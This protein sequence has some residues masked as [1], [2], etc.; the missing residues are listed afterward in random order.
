MFSCLYINWYYLWEMR[1]SWALEVEFAKAKPAVPNYYATL[2]Y[3]SHGFAFNIHILT[4]M[5][6]VLIFPYC[7][8]NKKADNCTEKQHANIGVCLTRVLQE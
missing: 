5:T 1:R 7:T 4:D 8:F 3:Q 2:R 6:L